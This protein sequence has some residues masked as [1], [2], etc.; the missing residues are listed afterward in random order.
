MR[1]TVVMN[2]PDARKMDSTLSLRS[3]TM[4]TK[5]EYTE[6]RF[7]FEVTMYVFNR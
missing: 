7:G 1:L 3:F 4:W 2:G 5:P 6:M